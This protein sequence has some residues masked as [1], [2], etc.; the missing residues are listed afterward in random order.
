MPNEKKSVTQNRYMLYVKGI[1]AG[2]IVTAV[3]IILFSLIMLLLD[4]N[5]K[6][7]APFA[8][9]SVAAGSFAA[10]YITARALGSKGY[11]VGIA[12]GIIVFV[13]I[14]LIALA[15]NKSGVTNNTLFHF[16]IIILSS[17]LGGILGVNKKSKKYI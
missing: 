9:V 11:L 7:A 3:F 13:I 17:V 1:A 10:A 2:L 12:V 14:T 16:I 15:V 6:F 8:T 4:L 5:Y